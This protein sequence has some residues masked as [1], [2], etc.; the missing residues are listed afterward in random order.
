MTRKEAKSITVLAFVDADGDLCVLG[1]WPGLPAK[2]G[3]YADELP[4]TPRGR[5]M[6][7]FSGDCT[8]FA[9]DC[10]EGSWRR[11]TKDESIAV[12]S[13]KGRGGKLV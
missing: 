10:P 7:L 8:P 6:W 3:F 4:D 2:Y 13:G 1:K 11:L 9:G 5:G 12:A